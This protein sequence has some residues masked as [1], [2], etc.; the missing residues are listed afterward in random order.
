MASAES[1]PQN[2]FMNAARKER[3]RV[4]IYLVNGIRLTIASRARGVNRMARRRRNVRRASAAATPKV[5]WSS[6]GGGV[7]SA[8]AAK[9]A[10]MAGTTAAA[11]PAAIRNKYEEAVTAAPR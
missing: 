7:C 2:D 8:P 1:H 3:K 6:R 10:I 5:R 9:A 4:E 11:A